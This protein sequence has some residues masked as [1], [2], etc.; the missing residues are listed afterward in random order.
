MHRYLLYILFLLSAWNASGQTR[1]RVAGFVKD[2]LSDE[3]LIGASVYNVDQGQGVSTDVQGYFSLLAEV[4]LRLRISFVGYTAQE[5][6]LTTPQDTLL[7]VFL[8]AGQSLQEVVIRGEESRQPNVVSMSMQEIQALPSVTGKPDVL[9]ALQMLPGMT[10]QGELS[11]VTLVRGGNPG[12]NSY[13]LD[14][15]PLIYVH[16]LGGF[17]SVFNPDII[18]HA[19]IYKGA[20]PAQYGE[21]LSSI[22]N[23]TQKEGDKSGFQGSFGIGVTDLSLTLE[24]PTKLKNSAFILTGRK[25]LT[26][27]FALLATGISKQTQTVFLYGFHDINGKFS[28]QPDARN[29]L[30]V[31]IYQGD[32]YMPIYGKSKLMQGSTLRKGNTWGNWLASAQWKHLYASRLFF[33][34]GLSFTHYRLKNELKTASGDSSNRVEYYSKERS[35][36]QDVSLRSEMKYAATS[37]WGLHVGLKA[38]SLLFVPY[39]S[40]DSYES[41]HR[42]SVEDKI[43]ALEATLFIDN[44]LQIGKQVSAD[45]GIRLTNYTTT[46]FTHFSPEPRISLSYSPL[47]ILRLHGSYMRVSQNAQ[48]IYNTGNIMANEIYIPS[49]K[50]IPVATSNQLTFG[51]RS[52]FAEGLWDVEAILYRKTLDKLTTYKEGYNYAMGDRHWRDKVLSGGQGLAQGLEVLLR[53]NRGDLSGFL[54]YTFARSTRTYAQINN[55]QSYD[56]EYD[57]P[58]TFNISMQYQL[59]KKWSLSAAFQYR[60]G[61]PYTPVTGR[62]YT[63]DYDPTSNRYVPYEVLVYG[64]KNSARMAAYHRLDL[65]AK[66]SYY[67]QRMHRKAEWTFGIY[68][69]YNRQNPYFY[70]YNDTEFGEM[71]RPKEEGFAPLYQYQI[72]MFP[73][74]PMVSYKVWFGAGSGEDAQR[75]KTLK[76]WFF[77]E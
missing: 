70:Y 31:N 34:T 15:T 24:G 72:A 22:M 4:P 1:I 30:H 28:W 25:T 21:K 42:P 45:I 32:D 74:I 8:Q 6:V 38:T 53:K 51:A 55:G 29:S 36:L 61:L 7:S 56:F 69:V 68:N 43:H 14:Q 52:H 60:S 64:E 41:R 18:N 20:F 40:Y 19:E 10:G 54:A 67:T 62:Y 16:H 48:L 57:S 5:F 50:D 17:L 37:Y 12:E 44:R 33:T 58:H 46:A 9:K 27:L 76:E 2:S 23:I 59:S 77:M 11:S 47:K 26:E 66:Y 75:K 65:S 39:A 13:L 49:G 73:F 3:R 71:H 35:A 63:L